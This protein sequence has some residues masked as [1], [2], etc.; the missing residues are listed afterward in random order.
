MLRH[1]H[2]VESHLPVPS[3]EDVVSQRTPY[4]LGSGARRLEHGDSWYGLPFEVMG[5]SLYIQVRGEFIWGVV[6]NK[7]GT[8]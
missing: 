7:G 1:R 8:I 4:R 5:C 3:G 6:I 2:I